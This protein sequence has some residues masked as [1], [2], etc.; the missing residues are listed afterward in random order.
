M[1]DQESL[2]MFKNLAFVGI[3]SADND[4]YTEEVKQEVLKRYEEC[5]EDWKYIL[6]PIG[7][8]ADLYLEIFRA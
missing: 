3:I 7:S 1:S 4:R 2:A 6:E 5:P 8:D